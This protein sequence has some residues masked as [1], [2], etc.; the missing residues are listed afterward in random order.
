VLRRS[1]HVGEYPNCFDVPGGHAEP[2]NVKGCDGV[3]WTFS[4]D[5]EE[6]EEDEDELRNRNIVNELFDS[7]LCEIR[8]ETNIPIKS[9][10][11]LRLLGIVRH[12][13]ETACG[14]GPGLAFVARTSLNSND[15][16]TLYGKGPSE[17]FESTSLSFFD[18]EMVLQIEDTP[19]FKNQFNPK[20]LG[21]ISLWTR[22]MR[23]CS[24]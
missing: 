4:D 1:K 11:D 16:K 24:S 7:A 10:S 15:I 2:K 9:I 6:L 18:L 5:D 14:S 13:R 17:A 20:C 23:A 21:A 19:L 3:A 12:N 22:Y 8:D